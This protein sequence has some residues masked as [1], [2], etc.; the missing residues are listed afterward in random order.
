MTRTEKL[1]TISKRL[2]IMT[3]CALCFIFA[4]FAYTLIL[5]RTL[6]GV[7]GLFRLFLAGF[8]ERFV[9]QILESKQTE[10]YHS[11]QD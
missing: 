7:V 2:I 9:P 6:S 10:I 8:S 1:L 5:R 11:Q 4:L 3:A